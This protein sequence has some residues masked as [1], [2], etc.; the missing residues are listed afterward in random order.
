MRPWRLF[1]DKLAP[2]WLPPVTTQGAVN[3]IVYELRE[4]F[5]VGKLLLLPLEQI[6]QYE[7]HCRISCAAD[8]RWEG[9]GEKGFPKPTGPG[10]RKQRRKNDG[11]LHI[12]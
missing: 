2:C 11:A 5:L 1:F 9:V 7:R 6:T 4:P 8:N 10:I 3:V 12:L